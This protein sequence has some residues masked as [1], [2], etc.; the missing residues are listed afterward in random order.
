MSTFLFAYRVPSDYATGNSQNVAAW[1]AWFE[2]MGSSVADVGN[3]V[4]DRR[5]LGASGSDKVLGGYSLITA[6]NLDAAVEMA[7]GCPLLNIGGAV[8][9]GE[10]Q[11]LNTA[12]GSTTV[13]IE[14]GGRV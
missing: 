5:T 2:S 1:K 4:I 9:V 13:R 12:S 10:L 11:I 6:D 3:P 8:E 14:E 7:K